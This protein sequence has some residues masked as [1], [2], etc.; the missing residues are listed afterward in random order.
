MSNRKLN[1]DFSQGGKTPMKNALVGGLALL[2]MLYIVNPT[3]GFFEVLPDNLPLIG[4]LDE[5]T[6]SLVLFNA[7]K[8]FG[9]DVFSLLFPSKSAAP[10]KSK[11]EDQKA[12]ESQKPAQ[13]PIYQPP[14]QE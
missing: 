14:A 7:M 3:A 2:S 12:S 4:N 6:A 11:K 5:L 10:A 9:I 1:F 8:Y 13:E